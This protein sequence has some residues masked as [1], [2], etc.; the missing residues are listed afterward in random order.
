MLAVMI[1]VSGGGR[2]RDPQFQSNILSPGEVPW[3]N[4]EEQHLIYMG[5][6]GTTGEQGM[7]G[8]ILKPEFRGSN[9]M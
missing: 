5:A 7:L 4:P 3:R 1:I 8:T 9:Q 2:P 6:P